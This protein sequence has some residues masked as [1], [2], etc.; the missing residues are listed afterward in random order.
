MAAKE[1]LDNVS[2]CILR[3]NPKLTTNV[4]L[5]VDTNDKLYLE[6]FDANDELA[7]V[8][9]KAFK[10]SDD[11]SYEYDLRRFYEKGTT[12]SSITYDV[13][14][15]YTD[16]SI[17]DS[18]SKQ[19]EFTYNY[20]AEG[21][22]SKFYDEEF[23][24]LA[25]IWL[26]KIIPDFF[27]IFR[28]DEPVSVNNKTATSENIN[29]AIV[30]DPEM[31]KE[32]ILK[33]STIIKTF[34]LTT[35][36]QLGRYLRNYKKKGNFPTSPLTFNGDR[37]EPS[38]FRGIDVLNGGFTDSSEYL[39]KD[40]V[41]KDKT[42]IEN[43]YF[44]STG[45]ERNNI[46]VANLINL[47]FLFDDSDVGNWEINRYFGIYVN[48]SHEG[49]FK[50]SGTEMLNDKVNEFQQLHGINS[51]NIIEP[52]NSKNITQTNTDGIAMYI[53]ADEIDVVYD[54]NESIGQTAL[55]FV[56][57]SDT[58]DDLT[59]IFYVQDKNNDFYNLKMGSSFDSGKLK[60]ADKSINWKNFTGFNDLITSQRA[61]IS[62]NGGKANLVLQV[63]DNP[64]LGDRLFVSLPIKQSYTFTP[65]NTI[66]GED[67]TIQDSGGHNIT[68]T[69]SDTDPNITCNELKAEWQANTNGTFKNYSVYVKN[70]TLV[71]R[72]KVFTGID[73]NFATSTSNPLTS[74][75][76]E[77][78]E[79]AELY[80]NTITADDT[81]APNIGE[82]FQRFY[83]HNGTPAEVAKAMVSA[84]NYIKNRVFEAVAVDDKI[85]ILSKFEG[86]RFNDLLLGCDR[87]L[88][89]QQIRIFAEN[90]SLDNDEWIIRD[91]AGGVQ[92]NKSRVSIELE[93]F[94][95]FN[96]PGRYL[97]SSQTINEGLELDYVKIR[98]VS[99]YVDEPIMDVNDNIIGFTNID[100]L[101]TVVT[102]PGKDIY[103]DSMKRIHLYDLFE[104]PFGRF[105]LFP[106]KDLDTDTYST[107]Y[108]DEKELILETNFYK[109]FGTTSLGLTQ[110]ELEDWVLNNEY[111]GLTKVLEQEDVD[112]E[113]DS[114]KIDSEYTRLEE[115]FIKELTTPSRVVPFINKWV[116]K[117]G[118]DV[119]ENDYRLN[120]SE[121][122]GIYNFSP[123][124][125]EF[126][127]NTDAFTH[128]WLY[129]QKLPSY[130]GL[131]PE[132]EM[133]KAF[134]YFDNA[135]NIATGIKGISEDYFKDYFIVDELTYP[136]LNM[137]VSTAEALLTANY[138]YADR[139]NVKRQKRYTLFEDGSTAAYSTTFFR[140]IK[141]IVKERIENLIQLNYNK[142][143]IQYKKSTRYN[144]YKFS[145]VLIP[146]DGTYEG[147][148]KKNIDIDVIENRT[149]KTI[150]LVVY[151]NL[152]DPANMN[153]MYL[154]RTI[155]YGLN[156]KY[157][158]IDSEIINTDGTIDFADITLSGALNMSTTLA[159]DGT[160]AVV[161][162]PAS[163][164]GTIFGALDDN[165]NKSIFLEE[166]RTNPEGAYNE[167]SIFTY[168]SLYNLTPIKVLSDNQL[169]VA[170]N[171]SPVGIIPTIPVDYIA[172]G[173]YVYKNGGYNIWESRLENLSFAEL[174]R[175]INDGDSLIN[176][177][178]IN[179]DGTEDFNEFVI[180]LQTGNR[181]MKPQYLKPASDEN[182]PVV[183]NLEK[184]IG[185]E[186][187]FQNTAYI[188]PII[189]HT[190]KY[191]PKCK[192]IIN[193]K[194]PY[195][196]LIR[197][198]GMSEIVYDV[199]QKVREYMKYSNTEIRIDE[200]FG[201]IDNMFYH[202]VNEV[203]SKGILELSTETAY[204]PSYPKIGEIAIDKRNFYTFTSN[205]D[206]AYYRRNIDKIKQEDVV[207]TRN[208]HEQKSFFASKV[209][210]IIDKIELEKFVAVEV[211]SLDELDVLGL[212]AQKPDNLNQLIY[213][214][215]T[216]TIY[217]DIYID[218]KLTKYISDAGVYDFFNKY[219][220]PSYG[221][222]KQKTIA[223][224]VSGYIE[225]NVLPRYIRN[226]VKF[227][228]G[229]SNNSEYNNT[230]PFMNTNIT[231][232][233]K[234]QKGL[235][236]EDNYRV[237]SLEA[238]NNFNIRII[239]NK[240]GGFY[241]SLS[242][243]IEIL[244]K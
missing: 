22:P 59:S 223:D 167:L 120:T 60:L 200:N 3:T 58:V 156:S 101:A 241:Y 57:T 220:K 157:E 178:T 87:V 124:E 183:F 7:K 98:R 66:P 130:Y 25:P 103:L 61:Y 14:R 125:D 199:H 132:S 142:N 169:E 33:K 70:G 43:D 83:N 69:A 204:Q 152:Q 118:K 140:G 95:Q 55:D 78:T 102:V 6:S 180:E 81:L 29:K 63:L 77:K 48:A 49:A 233:E 123:S 76:V 35:R 54:V 36:S 232:A 168:T 108:G 193:F 99:F 51:D 50:V 206:A 202:K 145:A 71:V 41:G 17:Q 153:G 218:K 62:D 38:L 207:G 42:I 131:Y 162:G 217:L 172:T 189:R 141:V 214:N 136:S 174:S 32:L 236:L 143:K 104:I 82:S 113:L 96:I 74:L 213:F 210:K 184:N 137:S 225:E 90:I 211:N 9:Y 89:I 192:D 209:M 138:N 234:I 237:V 135:I 229:K 122:F 1:L 203:N 23:G 176:Y 13:A 75:T 19:Y 205:W 117:N 52:D 128:E 97:R 194:E 72:E 86:E 222:G 163:G 228:V 121:A 164:P 160:L 240:I 155:L 110:P 148:K 161:P 158:T 224:D 197:T 235:R 150:T 34:D 109:D 146:T 134:S 112:T 133:N 92:S 10:V 80:K 111:L 187:D 85:V 126:S 12:P 26:D 151:V 230:H 40:Y 147:I 65:V 105:S 15:K 238:N 100:K 37:E 67:F 114:P 45:F 24:L 177:I 244:K 119:R 31:F 221:Y 149:F 88:F 20:G 139:H 2:A 208:I 201:L 216:N 46:A 94:N 30:E 68:I 127:R 5:I 44:L 243:T 190:G 186:L 219:I 165:G 18:F 212:D 188:Q 191:T 195:T 144:D 84:I 196:P 239:Y 198:R 79:S 181:I 242:P 116:Y 16:F 171:I 21:I 28:L 64:P 129:L 179:E 231:N 185:F 182:K 227:F 56:P 47:Q 39:Y 215:D 53:D 115:N 8:K 166:I 73:D 27:I 175:M 159:A 226:K 154:D 107:E 173:L 170:G 106:I 91:F 4:K 11:T 93:S